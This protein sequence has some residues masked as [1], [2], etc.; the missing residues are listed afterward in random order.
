MTNQFI[1]DTFVVKPS[2]FIAQ[3]KP[4]KLI[5]TVKFI[6]CHVPKKGIGGGGKFESL[7][8]YK[9]NKYQLEI[10]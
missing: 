5:K 1:Y 10:V 8:G 9:T 4:L 7:K 6:K 3:W 2:H